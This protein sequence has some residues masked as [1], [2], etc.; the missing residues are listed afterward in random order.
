[1]H[2]CVRV[3]VRE[4]RANLMF[5]VLR[6]MTTPKI[7]SPRESLATA[8][9]TRQ[10]HIMDRGESGH[11]NWW[12]TPAPNNLMIGTV[13]YQAHTTIFGLSARMWQ[14]TVNDIQRLS[15]IIP[16]NENAE[17]N[18]GCW[19]RLEKLVLKPLALLGLGAPI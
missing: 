4:P 12:P 10:A 1:M 13:E 8:L 9:N 16:A 18:E 5:Y 6:P 17:W 15:I 19:A 7:N 11:V 2:A 3:D 14:T